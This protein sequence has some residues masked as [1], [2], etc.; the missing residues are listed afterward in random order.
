MR[1]FSILKEQKIV[2]KNTM[3]QNYTII[4]KSD[5]KMK[6]GPGVEKQTCSSQ[7]SGSRDRT[8]M[9]RERGE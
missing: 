9:R 2:G 5:K 7:H 3:Q 4:Q 6:A 8:I 1:K